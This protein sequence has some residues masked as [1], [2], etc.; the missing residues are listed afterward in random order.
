MRVG[1][2]IKGKVNGQVILTVEEIDLLLSTIRVYSKHFW[3]IAGYDS[4]AVE[5]MDLKSLKVME[6]QL[7]FMKKEMQD[8]HSKKA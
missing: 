5:L 6:K 7:E 3:L 1:N 2:D 4:K 8:E